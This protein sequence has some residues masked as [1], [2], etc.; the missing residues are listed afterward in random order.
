MSVFKN[1][2]PGEVTC[3]LYVKNIAKQVEEKVRTSTVGRLPTEAASVEVHRL[4]HNWIS[5]HCL[6]SFSRTW[7]TSTAGTSTS[8]QRPR[9]ICKRRFL[10]TIITLLKKEPSMSCIGTARQLHEHFCVMSPALGS[11]CD[12]L[13]P[14]LLCLPVPPRRFDIVLM[15]EGRMK[16]QA[17]IGLPSEKSAERALRDTNGYVLNDKPLVVVSFTVPADT[18]RRSLCFLQWMLWML[19]CVIEGTSCLL[20]SC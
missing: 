20:S 10:F 3:R 8:R 2:E 16:G 4:K 1:Y 6:L 14:L 13:Y 12:F 15:K 7:S 18:C 9:E 19:L 5:T 17:F 11:S